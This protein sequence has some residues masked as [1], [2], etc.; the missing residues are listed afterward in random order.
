MKYPATFTPADEGGFVI[1]FRDIPE[2][3]S[4]GDDEAEALDTAADAL[5][6]VMDFYFEDRRSVPM[7]SVPRV[8][9][10]MIPL[11]LSA[12]SKVLL[13][14]EMLAQHVGPSELARRMGTSKQE[15]NRLTD[16]KHATKIDRIADAMAALGRELALVVRQP[17]S[18]R[19]F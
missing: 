13:L 3:I 6:T 10:R 7:P 18:P 4:Q 1:T 11:P 17:E 2:A 15:A 16:L 8:G 19:V 12:V 14:N 9:E 5:L